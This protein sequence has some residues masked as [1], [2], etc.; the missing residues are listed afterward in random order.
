MPR[1]KR[2]TIAGQSLYQIGYK[3]LCDNFHKFNERNK[4]KVSLCILSIFEK[5][6]SKTKTNEFVVKIER[7]N[8]EA[9]G[10]NLPIARFSVPS[11]S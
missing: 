1:T 4:I 2:E 10:N 7:G 8:P 11:I 3:Y 9:N 5:D 6:D